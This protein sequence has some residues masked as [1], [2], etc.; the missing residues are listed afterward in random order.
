MRS[1]KHRWLLSALSMCAAG[2]LLA[3]PALADDGKSGGGGGS[4]GGGDDHGGRAVT[5]TTTTNTTTNTS[6]GDGDRGRDNGAVV[7]PATVQ[8]RP[9][10][11]EH[12]NDAAEDAAEPAVVVTPPMTTAAVDDDD[13]RGPGNAEDRGANLSELLN[14]LNNEPTLLNN[15]TVRNDVD[16]E[17]ANDAAEAVEA[18][19]INIMTLSALINGLNLSATDAAALTT[20]VNNDTAAVQTFLNSGGANANAIDAALN[21]AGV[22]P[23]GV[24]AF[25]RQD[26]RLLAIISG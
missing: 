12:E 8:V 10:E 4:R 16:N 17:D 15:L 9:A 3:T 20:A 23:S 25:V 7:S 19:R 13:N 18:P 5:T 21:A 6:R 2:A 26:G 1:S 14:R 24:L 22:A 11:V